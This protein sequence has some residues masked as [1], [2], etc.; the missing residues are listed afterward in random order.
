MESE[1]KYRLPL[2]AVVLLTLLAALWAGL[3]R[4]GWVLPPLRPGLPMAHGPLMISGLLGTV[5]ALERAVALRDKWTYLGPVLSALGAVVLIIDGFNQL[6]P[7]LLALS[8]LAF[9]IVSLFMV[10]RV[11]AFYTATMA[12]GAAAWFIGNV[13]WLS[14]WAISEIVYWWAGF[15][16]LTIVGERLELSRVTR[17]GRLGH[18]LFALAL[19]I[20][21]AGLILSIANYTA[22]V[23]LASLG[24]VVLALWLLAFDIARRTVRRPGLTRFIAVNLLFGNG[25]LFIGGLLGMRYA[26]V[27]AGPTYDAMLHTLFLG[28]VLSL[29]FAHALIIVPAVVGVNVPYHKL[30]Y[31]PVILLHVSLAMRV[32]G[33]LNLWRSMRLWGGLLNEVAVLWFLLLLAAFAMRERRA[34]RKS[35]TT[36]PS[37]EAR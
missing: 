7:V 11:P 12:M 3:Y 22:G 30:F 1:A 2:M 31:G 25:W 9:L 35:L 15:L 36:A 16:I 10:Y 4:I 20:T 32:I 29:I 8:S 27:I 14:G 5:I 13:L 28:F 6:G 24:F 23:R 34:T 17:P 21:V 33:D 19:G 18:M 26:G 37:T